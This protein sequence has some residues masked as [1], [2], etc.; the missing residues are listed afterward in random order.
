MQYSPGGPLPPY[1]FIS[2]VEILATMLEERLDSGRI[3][4]IQL[5]RH[6]PRLSNLFFAGGLI[7][8]ARANIEEALVAR[9]HVKKVLWISIKQM[10]FANALSGVARV[11]LL[12]LEVATEKGL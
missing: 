9:D 8:V 6:G 5:S 11:C 10:H 1:I 2:A 7:H 3:K 12:A 4:G